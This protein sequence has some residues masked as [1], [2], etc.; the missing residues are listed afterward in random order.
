MTATRVLAVFAHPD[1]ESLA[2]GGLLASYAGAGAEVCVATPTWSRD[3]V[4]AGEL[5]AAV[6]HL[7]AGGPRMWGYADA[8]IPESSPGRAR[9]VDTSLEEAAAAVGAEIADFAPDLVVTHDALGGITGHEDHVHTHRASARAAYDASVELLLATHPHSVLPAVREVI[10]VRRSV[11]TVPDAEV[12]LA[13]DATPWLAPKIAAILSHRSEIE[14]GALPGL[15]AGLAPD[16]RARLLGT[17]WYS[18]A[19]PG[20]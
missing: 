16:V 18:R 3:S 13:F 19:A 8:R 17:E 12:D 1:D 2:A 11:C 20:V 10:G 15:I 4:R 6:R 14:R 7:G 9:W 5:R